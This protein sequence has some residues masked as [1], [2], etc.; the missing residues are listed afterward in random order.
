MSSRGR[1]LRL[2][3]ERWIGTDDAN[4]AR[5]TRLARGARG[6]WRWV[7]VEVP[8]A[9]GAL[10]IMFFRHNDGSWFVYPPE[11][12]RPVMDAVRAAVQTETHVT[13]I[14]NHPLIKQSRQGASTIE[15]L[16]SQIRSGVA[17]P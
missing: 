9:S 11:N 8:R 15:A 12:P 6:P 14:A 4:H 10:R 13:Q 17:G 7:C 3:V 2:L 1:S 5:V 16:N